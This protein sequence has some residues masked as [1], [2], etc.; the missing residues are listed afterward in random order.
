MRNVYLV[1]TFL[2]AFAFGTNAQVVINE[3]YGGGGNSGA[4]YK[5]DFIELYNNGASDVSLAGWSVQYASKTGTSWGVTALS[6]TIKA[7][8]Y[9]L[10]Q[11]AKGSGGTVDLPTPDATG[12][13]GMSG[14]DGKVALA[15]STTA[16]TGACPKADASVIDFVGFGGANCY[17]GTGPTPAPNNT[18]SVQRLPE[19]FDSQD[20]SA[21]F[22]TGAP[23]PTNG[24][25]APDVTAPLVLTYSPANGA[26]GVPLTFTGNIKF[27][28]A[29]KKGT[30]GNILVKLS[31]NNSTVQ[32]IDLNS[33]TV[34]GANIYFSVSGLSLSTSYYFTVD[35]GTLTDMAGNAFAGFSDNAT[36]T[37]TST[38]TLPTGTVD[39]TYDLEQC[40]YS[41]PDGFSAFS[42][43]GSATWG[44]SAFG[45]N[46]SDPTLS[47]GNA[48][49]MN[50]FFGG[51]NEVNEDWF[52]SPSFDLTATN[53]PLLSF[54]TRNKFNGDQLQ[55]KV[56]TN[57]PGTGDPTAYTWTDMN[58]QF[59]TQASD[60]WTLSN[61][62]NLS[63]FK[64]AHTYFAF[65]YTS[66]I[67]DGARWTVDD[68]RIDNSATPP[69]ATLTVSTDEVNFGYVPKNKEVVK[70]FTFTGNDITSGVT[71]TV[72]GNFLISKTNSNFTASISYDM[73]EANNVTKT[74]Y[75]Q[76]KPTTYNTPYDD[77]IKI[78]TA[79]VADTYVGV[80]GNSINAALTL[81]V[82]NW[83]LEWFGS[84]EPNM[85][86]AD[87]DLQASNVKK[88]TVAVA[89]DL[90]A[91]AEVVSE[92]RLQSV[93]DT[94]NYV[95]GAGAYAYVIC[96]YGSHTNPF[97]TSPGTLANAQKEAFVYKT[98]VI[99][100]VST[101]ALV[102]DGVNTAADLNNPA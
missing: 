9:Y 59:P 56:S 102:T 71:L 55:L 44:C 22:K 33:I 76:F 43:S 95:F 91:F 1:L 85:G 26:T 8:G 49:Q 60:V 48:A 70:D 88:V 46:P 63:A 28:E 68:I 52:I 5:Y 65:V 3:V 87:K 81:E 57:Y 21:D 24:S 93:V 74:V 10:I 62:I 6:G 101:S 51:S 67:N 100:N 42:V 89:A 54:W 2:L 30:A 82:V 7:G 53:Y 94:L 84:T 86:P 38:A 73:A 40:N 4:T 20:N 36:W 15:N 11:L 25:T 80:F 64:S 17:E 18:N 75:V 66:T 77:S 41:L 23:S 69:P 45:R 13:T 99:D 35:A 19:G 16:L 79:G 72:G 90:Y 50:G 29:V 14:S 92:T 96:D 27:N 39:H 32:T 37:F 98:S 61:N 78:S 83:N 31:S 47:A 58:G 34:N 97:E 12:T